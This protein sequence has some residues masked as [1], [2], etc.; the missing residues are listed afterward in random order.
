MAARLTLDLREA[1]LSD[2]QRF[3]EQALALNASPTEPVTVYKGVMSIP[4]S[5]VKRL[6]DE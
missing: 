3:V 4:V 5:I 2:I 1:S 6:L